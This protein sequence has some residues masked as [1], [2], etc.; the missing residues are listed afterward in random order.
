MHCQLRSK[1]VLV[2]LLHIAYYTTH[3][4]CFGTVFILPDYQAG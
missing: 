3:S 2:N 1:Q 4:Q